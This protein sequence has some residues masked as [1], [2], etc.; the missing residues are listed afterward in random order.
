[1]SRVEVHGRTRVEVQ[2]GERGNEASQE[3]IFRGKFECTVK[4]TTDDKF[5]QPYKLVEH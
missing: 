3:F 2:H 5:S 1:M 4:D